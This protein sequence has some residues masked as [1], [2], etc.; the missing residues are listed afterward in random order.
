MYKSY[1]HALQRKDRRYHLYRYHERRIPGGRR[2]PKG[3]TMAVL[4][5]PGSAGN[6]QQVVAVETPRS[7]FDV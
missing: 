6:Y 3:G 5:L 4:F 2:E 7:V 1:L